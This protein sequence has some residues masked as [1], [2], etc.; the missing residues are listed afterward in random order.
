MSLKNN[1]VLTNKN[2]MIYCFASLFFVIGGGIIP[3]LVLLLH[4]DFNISS[5]HLGFLFIII[6]LSL[7]PAIVLGGKLADKYN[8]KKLIIVFRL[9]YALSLLIYTQI[10]NSIIRLFLLLLAIIFMG[11]SRPSL[12]AFTF[13][14]F[15]EADS[16][17]AISVI[18]IFQNIGNIF[19]PII[20]AILFFDTENLFSFYALL[21]FL[22]LLT[23]LFFVKSEKGSYVQQNKEEDEEKLKPVKIK[24]YFLKRSFGIFFLV[25]VFYEFSYAQQSYALPI[26]LEEFGENGVLYYGYLLSLNSALLVCL[27]PIITFFT[28]KSKISILLIFSGLFC[29]IGFGILFFNNHL[30]VLVLATF[31]WTI[32]EILYGTNG[33][34]L[35][36]DT[37]FK[38]NIGM[39]SSFMFTSRVIGMSLSALLASFL[40]SQ[41]AL[42]FIWIIVFSISVLSSLILWLYTRKK[43]V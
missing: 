16:K 31:I 13:D 6:M 41:N 33:I 39:A 30:S 22:G 29:G 40:V 20:S 23:V 18:Y 28:K 27:T 11:I 5:S 17:K 7:I 12:T 19:V 24:D 35:L 10:N 25:L 34:I 26:K 3:F 36:K 1:A 37:L 42:H 38:K 21:T 43:A 9:G 2:F 14:L 8:K 32:G 4:H 15:P